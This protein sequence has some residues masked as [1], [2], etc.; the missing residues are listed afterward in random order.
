[1]AD[2]IQMS[3][4]AGPDD[5]NLGSSQVYGAFKGTTQ[6]W[7]PVT[8]INISNIHAVKNVTSSSIPVYIQFYGDSSRTSGGYTDYDMA[9][10]GALRNTP[11]AGIPIYYYFF[12][13]SGS[14]VTAA[15]TDF[16]SLINSKSEIRFRCEG[17]YGVGVY[18]PIY[19][20]IID[21]YGNGSEISG[22]SGA[23]VSYFEI[24]LKSYGNQA[25]II[26]YDSVD[27]YNTLESIAQDQWNSYCQNTYGYTMTYDATR[28]GIRIKN[29]SFS[30]VNNQY[31]TNY[32]SNYKVFTNSALTNYW[33]S[34]ILR[35]AKGSSSQGLYLFSI[36][37]HSMP[38]NVPY[39]YNL[40]YEGTATFPWA[41]KYETNIYFT[42]GSLTYY[43]QLTSS[44]P[45]GSSSSINLNAVGTTCYVNTS[46]NTFY[47]SNDNLPDI[48]DSNTTEYSYSLNTVSFSGTLY[49]GFTYAM[50]FPYCFR[51]SITSDTTYIYY[52]RNSTSIKTHWYKLS[53]P[54]I[55]SSINDSAYEWYIPTNANSITK[56][57]PSNWHNRGNIRVYDIFYVLP[58]SGGT[59]NSM[60][61]RFYGHETKSLGG[62]GSKFD[63]Y[64][65][66][67]NKMDY[68]ITSSNFGTWYGDDSF[69]FNTWNH[70]FSN[71]TN[72]IVS[73][74][75][76][77][78]FSPNTT[79]SNQ[80]Q[81]TNLIVHNNTKVFPQASFTGGTGDSGS[82]ILRAWSW[83]DI[84]GRGSRLY[85]EKM[86]AGQLMGAPSSSSATQ[87]LLVFAFFVS[88]YGKAS[89]ST[90]ITYLG[91]VT[92]HARA[93]S[94][95]VN[96]SK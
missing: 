86:P 94:L 12:N 6:V 49:S 62:T 24:K 89:C 16:N 27:W 83:G 19:F 45:S 74:P 43:T 91:Y 80:I 90:G 1:M 21:N 75:F 7:P 81:V 93:T 38:T 17:S 56:T 66:L 36:K 11:D 8:Q 40:Y 25:T 10:L 88:G 5:L 13:S 70:S 57:A 58:D 41:P 82:F 14:I 35:N 2:Y 34:D 29:S 54:L 59:Y 96:W 95:S 9:T 4:Q 18:L 76:I 78:S 68:E 61:M 92:A 71:D 55:D 50:K 72:P 84:A 39:N 64:G 85:L 26:P 23:S 3:I 37:N 63:K 51:A 31:N 65:N 44:G 87:R 20:I 53:S 48:F 46:N 30:D 33:E 42:D 22:G 73:L 15:S 77:G 79:Q 69:T 52:D 67:N 32:P 47:L 28:I 60:A